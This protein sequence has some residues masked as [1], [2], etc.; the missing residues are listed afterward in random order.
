M[1]GKECFGGWEMKK[2]LVILCLCCL[3][4]SDAMSAVV[5][6]TSPDDFLYP[7]TTI[8]FDDGIDHQAANTRYLSEGVEFSRDD[9]QNIAIENWQDSGRITTSQPNVLATVSGPI[10]GQDVT[11]WTTHLNAGFVVPVYEVGAFFGNDQFFSFDK[12]TLSAYGENNSLLGSVSVA[13]NFNTS[14]DQFI[15]LSSD[16]LI[17]SVRFQNSGTYLCV[18]IDDFQFSPVPE[19]AT[20]LL[21]GLGGLLM[22]KRKSKGVNMHNCLSTPLL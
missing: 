21:F 14:V 19:P 17:H 2:Y 12:I 10:G 15:G 9:G 16:E 13:T 22:L 5:Q 7:S 3:L 4:A 6:I 8:D 18:V 1:L 11:G 20:L